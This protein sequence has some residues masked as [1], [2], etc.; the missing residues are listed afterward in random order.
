ML[1]KHNCMNSEKMLTLK[2]AIPLLLGLVVNNLQAAATTSDQALKEELD[3]LQAENFVYSPGKKM[4]RVQDVAAAVFVIS[5]DDIHRSG[6]TNIPDVLRM[7]PG[8]QVA[9]INANKWA[10]TARGFNDQFSSKL[11]VMID[12][13]TVY[14]PLF[15]GVFWHREDTPLEDVD[16]IEVIRGAGA[17]MWGANAVNGVINIITK[18]AK[19]TQ[20]LLMTVG[21]GNQEQVFGSLRYGGQIG[22][23]FHYRVYGKGFKRNNNIT[24]NNENAHD[25]WENY[26]GGFKTQWQITSEDSVTAQGDIF[27]SRTGDVEDYP[28]P[29]APFISKSQDSPAHHS[30]GNLQARWKHKISETS[31]TALQLYYKHNNSAGMYGS[32][33]KTQEQVLDID[34]QHRF[35]FLERHD[36]IWG[37]NYRYFVFNSA[38]NFKVDFEPGNRNLQLI[39]GFVQD[40]ISLLENELKL[41]IGTRLERNDFTGFEIQP[42]IRLLWTPNKQHS[43]WGAISRAVRTPSLTDTSTRFRLNIPDSPDLP[44]PAMVLVKGNDE[45][46]SESVIDY[47]IGYRTQLFDK[48]SFDI[49]AFYNKYNRLRIAQYLK[50]KLVDNSYIEL[51]VQYTNAAK[52]ETMGLEM[53]TRWQPLDW[54][55]LQASYSLFK[56][57]I[58]VLNPIPAR[59][60]LHQQF[61]FK[62]ALDLPFNLQIDPM[63]RY[64]DTDVSHNI[65]HYVAFDLRAAWKPVKNLEFSVVGQNL[66]DNRHLEYSDEAFAIPVTEIR[67]S[68]FGKLTVSF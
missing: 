21:A 27:H 3:F 53:T 40:D 48:F 47:E 19:D 45:F 25:D 50:P 5:Q 23:D 61:Y 43:V 15:S 8:I 57:N 39:T 20:G 31:E 11:L 9:Q 49:T 52:G 6:A 26:Q 41:T 2:K 4:Q 46:K 28:L 22:D 16:R 54:M 42:N 44:L 18:K 29:V 14:T 32:P 35:N 13:R 63:V 64:V 33:F 17:A 34:F 58:Q 30:G 37:V 65:P 10:I 67:R 56:E 12:G 55:R 1:Q 7:V 68:I 66:F 24:V 59:E 51:P 36:V 60:S 38:G 62:A